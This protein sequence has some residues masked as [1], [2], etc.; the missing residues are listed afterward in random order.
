[1][2]WSCGIHGE[3]RQVDVSLVGGGELNLGLLSSFLQA[4]HGHVVLGHI[5]A[6]LKFRELN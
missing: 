5:D 3:V 4:L 6:L 2:L 1:M